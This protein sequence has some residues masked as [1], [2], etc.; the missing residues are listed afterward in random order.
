MTEQ[1]F[2]HTIDTKL[3]MLSKSVDG[4]RI[5]QQQNQL[6]SFCNFNDNFKM[7]LETLMAK[8]DAL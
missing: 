1:H 6:P 8:V 5:S 4:S 2:R 7:Q 3:I